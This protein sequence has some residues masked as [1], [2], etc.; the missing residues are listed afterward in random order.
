MI[1][2][3]SQNRVLEV[4]I[5]ETH[6]SGENM[7]FIVFNALFEGYEIPS[8]VNEWMLL[9]K[10]EP[11]LRMGWNVREMFAKVESVKLLKHF[12]VWAYFRLDS[13]QFLFLRDN[14]ISLPK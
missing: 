7:K 6:F 10:P 8:V 9:N 12:F 13:Q 4:F 2:L 14:A 11:F 3:C 1:Y 5:L